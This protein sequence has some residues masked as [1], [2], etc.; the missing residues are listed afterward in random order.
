MFCD[1]DKTTL[2]VLNFFGLEDRL[3]PCQ[4]SVSARI[5]K[6]YKKESIVSSRFKEINIREI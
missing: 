4:K 1:N 3:N 6:S 5:T 2:P